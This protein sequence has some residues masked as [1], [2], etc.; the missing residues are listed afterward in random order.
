MLGSPAVTA[1]APTLELGAAV[2][3]GGRRVPIYL[4]G[5]FQWGLGASPFSWSFLVC[6]R[7]PGLRRGPALGL[8]YSVALAFPSSCHQGGGKA[9][10]PSLLGIF[11]LLAN[12]AMLHLN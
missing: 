11:P 1:V 2:G 7:Y 9:P 3:P 10:F 5:H 4:G 12:R 6:A 8:V